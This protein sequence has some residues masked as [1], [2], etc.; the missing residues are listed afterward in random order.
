[1]L[2]CCAFWSRKGGDTAS[3]W[4]K[5]VVLTVVYCSSGSLLSWAN[6]SVSM[7]EHRLDLSV[8]LILQNSVTCALIWVLSL[9]AP[10]T[11]GELRVES[12]DVILRQFVPLS[13]IFCSMLVT[14]LKAFQTASIAAVVVQR[15]LLSLVVAFMEYAILSQGL[16]VSAVLSLLGI[17]AG[18]I[19]FGIGDVE[20]DRLGYGWLMLNIL[21]SATFQ[22]FNKKLVHDVKLSA[23]GFSFI[24][25]GVSVAMFLVW[26][27]PSGAL[28]ES[29]A[30]LRSPKVNLV[31]LSIS[32]V[33]GFALSV[34]A[35]ALSKEVSATTMMVI[36]NSNKFL[37]VMGI[38]LLHLGKPIGAQGWAGCVVAIVSAMLYARS[39]SIGAA[40]NSK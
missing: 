7:G 1:M 24:N 29:V 32:C 38:E 5:C 23:F 2:F 35:F 40:S 9:A 39:K 20:F 13:F 22:I 6:K 3:A 19:T 28:M 18:A 15:N 27:L 14:S 33:L 26:A 36:N 37:L 4:A 17:L 10:G 30:I 31:A 12:W 25:N 8:V 16:G 34:S 21:V 11:V